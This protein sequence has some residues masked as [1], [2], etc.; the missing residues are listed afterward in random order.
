[1]RLLLLSLAMIP[2]DAFVVD[3]DDVN[4]RLIVVVVLNIHQ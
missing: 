2:V 4:L 3:G 1:M